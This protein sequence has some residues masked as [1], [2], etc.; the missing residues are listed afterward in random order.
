M[1]SAA[2]SR[3]LV[4]WRLDWQT[5]LQQFRGTDIGYGTLAIVSVRICC[6]TTLDVVVGAAVEDV[7]MKSLFDMGQYP[8][9]LSR[10]ACALYASCINPTSAG[11][12]YLHALHSDIASPVYNMTTSARSSHVSTSK[13][14]LVMLVLLCA[15]EQGT[16]CVSFVLICMGSVC[17][18][19]S[20]PELLFDVC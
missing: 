5:R 15:Q 6:A 4:L 19:M 17:L 11:V 18:C 2:V 20:L 9:E 1:K 14:Y 8:G 16:H 10:P 12:T 7:T 3:N 13:R